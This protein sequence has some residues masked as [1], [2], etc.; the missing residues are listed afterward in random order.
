MLITNRKYQSGS[1]SLQ[2]LLLAF[3]CWLSVPKVAA[4]ELTYKLACK[5]LDEQLERS[6]E[7]T[8]TALYYFRNLGKHHFAD[9]TDWYRTLSYIEQ[10]AREV[11]GNYYAQICTEIGQRLHAHGQYQDAY[12][13]L[14]KAQTDIRQHPPKDKRFLIQFHQALGLSYFYFKRLDDS[15]KQF[16]L[17]HRFVQKG[18]QDEIS[19]LNTLGLINR[20]QGYADSSKI[21]FEKALFLAKKLPHKPWIG[22]LSGNLGHYYWRKKEYTKARYLINLDYTISLE[23]NQVGSAVNALSL[24]IDIDLENNRLGLAQKKLVRLEEMVRDEYH[25]E[26]YR[27]LYRAKTAVL[28]AAGNHREALESYRKVVLYND[29]ISKK[30]DIEN[31][32][33]TEF[34]INFERKQAEVSLLHE[35]KKRDEIIIYGLIGI[36]V[37]VIVVFG[38]I[39]NLNA[40]RRRREREIAEL[41]QYQVE[42]ELESTDKEMRQILSNLIEKNA[43]IEHLTEEISQIHAVPEQMISE[44]KIKM[45]DKLQSFTLL[46]D[47]DWLEF[48]KLFEKLNPTFFNSVFAHSPDLTNA[49]IRLITL[50]KLNLSNLE[51]SRALGI[52]PDSVRKTS[53]RLRKKLNMELHEELVKFILSL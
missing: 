51:M 26:Q 1:R 33:K 23:T 21:Y 24:L 12:Y 13:Y 42:A 17:A 37:V 53:L 19:I 44:E 25:T 18:H 40:K 49:E 48:K 31:L 30:T 11:R 2:V 32:K 35:K 34:Q 15:R 3:T 52:S 14:Y 10:R 29:T 9:K 20:D 5:Q 38:V 8:I 4:Q 41:K 36:T 45:I 7:P 16:L 22:V 28:E 6:K 43:L 47:D 46:T 27:V 50:I 39:I